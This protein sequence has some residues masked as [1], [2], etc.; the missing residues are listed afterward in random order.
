MAAQA[1]WCR[2]GGGAQGVEWTAAGGRRPPRGRRWRPCLPRCPCWSRRSVPGFL[3]R[4]NPMSSGPTSLETG[5]KVESSVEMGLV[6]ITMLTSVKQVLLM[7]RDTW[8][9]RPD[10][11]RWWCVH[12]GLPGRVLLQV[13]G[14]HVSINSIQLNMTM[15]PAARVPP[16]T[17]DLKWSLGARGSCPSARGQRR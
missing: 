12:S 3:V 10:R 4:K 8:E 11:P 1:A 2:D 5:E 16:T 14:L 15:N 9:G 13:R 6:S 17:K 7:Y